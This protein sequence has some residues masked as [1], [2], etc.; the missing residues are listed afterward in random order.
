MFFRVDHVK[1]DDL[2]KSKESEQRLRA[3]V[4]ALMEEEPRLRKEEE[5]LQLIVTEL[6]GVREQVWKLM[7][8]LFENS[9]GQ[10]PEERV[11]YSRFMTAVEKIVK[12]SELQ[13]DYIGA[14]EALK[15]SRVCHDV[16][17]I[18]ATVHSHRAMILV[19]DLARTFKPSR[20]DISFRGY[21]TESI[22]YIQNATNALRSSLSDQI[23]ALSHLA[24]ELHD[25]RMEIM[26]RGSA[27]PPT[28]AENTVVQQL[29][30][31]ARRRDLKLSISKFAKK[32]ARDV[33]FAFAVW[34]PTPE[35]EELARAMTGITFGLG[36][37]G[38]SGGIGRNSP[39]LGPS[40]FEGELPGYTLT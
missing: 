30:F 11:L 3:S 9:H 36:G 19:P 29:L 5:R 23:D 1:A 13:I 10:Y 26:D 39:S 38:Q 15:A 32:T 37:G 17:P 40:D 28:R 35:E 18:M 33:A 4:K 7:N 2:P 27:N 21:I 6:E 12:D 31:P 22:L 8:R 14:Y 20:A 24:A 16:D 34:I 25:L